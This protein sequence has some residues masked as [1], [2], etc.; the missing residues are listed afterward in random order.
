MKKI[1]YYII[2]KFLGTFFFAL[3]LIIVVSV[4]FDF[5]EKVD[6]FIEKNA[7]I[8]AI[9]FDYYL[10][11]IP[12]FSNLYTH[13][14]VF[15]AVI[16]FTSKMA[17]HSEVI[18]IL[19]CGVSYRR[20]MRP[21]FVAASVIAIFTFALGN[22]VIPYANVNRLKFE[23]KY[24]N[25]Q[26]RNTERNIHKQLASNVFVY[27]ETYNTRSDRGSRFSLEKIEDGQLVSKMMADY[28]RWDT[29]KQKWT[30]HNY[31]IR[32]VD[33]IKETISEGVDIDTTLNLFPEEFKRTH[34][35]VESMPTPVLKKFINQEKSR[36]QESTNYY[37]ELYRRSASPFS[38]FIMTIIGMALS[39]RKMRGGMGMH[40]GFGIA[41][42]FSYILFMQ[43]SKEF[44]ISGSLQPM[45][46]V[47]IPNIIYTII[48]F[49]LYRMAPK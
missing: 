43:I 5:S 3:A 23:E 35:I 13:L 1:D 42:S 34:N 20:L 49:F 47:W 30:A 41:L 36:G 29:A 6:D 27:L 26:Y 7:P 4:V 33:G 9:L 14:F 19:S 45:L 44:S 15:I 11:F 21:Y 28:I 48:A 12:Y 46:G 31:W 2:K 25:R 22:Y 10:N 37:I 16:Y 40:I 32:E 38:V 18:A 17:T 8:N 39:T 24:F